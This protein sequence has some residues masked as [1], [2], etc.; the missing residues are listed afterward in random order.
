MKLD[1]APTGELRVVDSGYTDQVLLDT[2]SADVLRIKAVVCNSLSDLN[3]LFLVDR[4]LYTNTPG[5]PLYMEFTPQKMRGM[6]TPL[7]ISE[8]KLYAVERIWGVQT[9]R[10]TR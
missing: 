6:K 7:I 3:R 8:V 10:M 4:A 9:L 5:V 2:V 1:Q